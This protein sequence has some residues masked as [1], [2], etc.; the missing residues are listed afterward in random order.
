M[1]RTHCTSSVRKKLTFMLLRNWK[2]LRFIA[3]ERSAFTEHTAELNSEVGQLNP[4]SLANNRGE[5]VADVK[6][7]ANPGGVSARSRRSFPPRMSPVVFGLSK[8]S[9]RLNPSARRF[10]LQ[11]DPLPLQKSVFSVNQRPL[12]LPF[13]LVT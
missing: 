6:G 12:D 3:D 8:K 13:D 5:N 9:V 10:E 11:P 1:R 7:G 4:S 2:Q